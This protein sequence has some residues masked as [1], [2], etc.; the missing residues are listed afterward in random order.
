MKFYIY[1]THIYRSSQPLLKYY[2]PL[3]EQFVRKQRHVV[4]KHFFP[5]LLSGQPDGPDL[6]LELSCMRLSNVEALC[7]AMVAARCQSTTILALS[8]CGFL[9]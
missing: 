2:T 1:P 8:K 5:L 4:K 7:G 3:A 6:V 9:C